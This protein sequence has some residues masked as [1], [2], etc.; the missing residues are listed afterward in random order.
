MI[1]EGHGASYT[2][3]HLANS[4]G[5][6]WSGEN[7]TDQSGW[8]REGKGVFL[9]CTDSISEHIWTINTRTQHDM[10]TV[11]NE[12]G[13]FLSYPIF[14]KDYIQIIQNSVKGAWS[15]NPTQL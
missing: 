14:C 12:V 9:N 3:N 6:E 8:G 11:H 5:M 7:W 1:L 13:P 4:A 15:D 10:S 2:H